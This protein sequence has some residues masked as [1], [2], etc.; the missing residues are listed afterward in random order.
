[1]YS[2]ER[3]G[4]LVIFRALLEAH[5]FRLQSQSLRE[6]KSSEFGRSLIAQRPFPFGS[7]IPEEYQFVR[8]S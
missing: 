8:M 7:E 5:L 1:M 6:K 2:P 4:E 3:A